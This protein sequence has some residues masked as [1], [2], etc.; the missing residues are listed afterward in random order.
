MVPEWEQ[1]LKISRDALREGR[2]NYE[3][4][5]HVVTRAC[6]FCVHE[7]VSVTRLAP[8]RWNLVG[9]FVDITARQDAEL[10]L[11]AEKERLAVTLGSMGEGV[12]TI[13]AHCHVLFM[14]RAAAGMTEW[15]SAEAVGRNV[16]DICAPARRAD[17]AG[18]QPFLLWKSSRAELPTTCPRRRSSRAVP[19][20]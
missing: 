19:E 4:E 20:G 7:H 9:V 3:Q 16:S 15:E 10:A 13:D 2:R 17:G 18:R 8:D 5:F 14:N 11:A 1:I 12:I 6:T